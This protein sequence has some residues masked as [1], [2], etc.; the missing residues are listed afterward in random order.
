DRLARAL[1]ARSGTPD[2]WTWRLATGR[3][4]DLPKTFRFPPTPYRERKFSRGPGHCCVCGQPVYRLGWHADL[5]DAGPN[6][7]AEW[8]AV[9][10]TAWDFWGAP[11]DYVRLLKRLQ[12]RRCAASGQRLLKTAE[13]DHRMPLFRVWQEHRELPWPDLLGFWGVRNLQV[14]NREAHAA[15][16]AAEAGYRRE[17]RVEQTALSGDL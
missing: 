16:C 15:K 7:N 9:C 17:A 6:R 4:R 2:G 11:S 1:A 5:W 3:A 14:I 8:H 10:V 12:V 13:V